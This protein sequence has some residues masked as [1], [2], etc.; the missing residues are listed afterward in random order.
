M[1]ESTS[2]SIVRPVASGRDI[3]SQRLVEP[4][5]PEQGL[6]FVQPGSRRRG[7]HG[8]R[9]PAGSHEQNKGREYEDMDVPER[10]V[11]GLET[12]LETP[13]GGQP[14]EGATDYD[15]ANLSI[16]FY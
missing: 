5:R 8:S 9:A 12:S 15:N 2:A 7:G 16:N 14:A 13:S 1:Q 4:A 6:G 10:Y 11:T 3:A